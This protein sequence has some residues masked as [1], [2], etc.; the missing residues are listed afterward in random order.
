M[1]RSQLPLNKLKLQ[2]NSKYLKKF[3]SKASSTVL[4]KLGVTFNQ[5]IPPNSTDTN[6]SSKIGGFKKLLSSINL[7]SAAKNS[8]SNGIFGIKNLDHY[9]GFELLQEQA[10]N[11]IDQL[12]KEAN[13]FDLYSSN[14][15]RNLVH[16]FDDISNE[17]CRVADL[18]EFV[19]TSHPDLNYRNSANMV[20]HSILVFFIPTIDA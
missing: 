20:N 7:S 9:H 11:R 10:K 16:I 17:L 4:N 12:T 1:M 13:D 14:K 5:K 19:R 3:H 8:Y 6:F 18:A 2:I 15:K